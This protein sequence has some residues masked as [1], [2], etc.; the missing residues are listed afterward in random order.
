MLFPLEIFPVGAL[1]GSVTTAV[2]I[3]V[4]V[5]VFYNIRFGTTLSGLVV[6]GYLVPLFLIKP[7]SGWVIILEAIM[8][9]FLAKLI[10]ERALVKAKLGEMF[11]RDRFFILILCS[12]L[13]RVVSDAFVLPFTENWLLE[14][15]VAQ[16]LRSDLH[17]FGLIIIALCANQFWNSGIKAGSATLFLYLITTYLVISEL[18]IPYTNFNISTLSFMYEDIA[19]S[20]LASPK[21]YIILVTAAFIASRMNLKYGWDY[22]GILIPSLLA[23]QW[24][25]PSKIVVTFIE[26][27][28]ILL[29]SQLLLRSPF[30]KNLNIEGGKQ[31]LFFFNIGFLYKILLGFF[32]AG[33]FPYFNITDLYGFGYLLST[34]IALKMY[35]K[36]LAVKMTRTIIQTSFSA[37]LIAS[38][39]G[40]TLTLVSFNPFTEYKA[41]I[42]SVRLETSEINVDEAINKLITTSFNDS[43]PS[44][45]ARSQLANYATESKQFFTQIR[46][47]K[48]LN[49]TNVSNELLGLANLLGF[50]LTLF[51]DQFLLIT[52]QVLERGSGFY[53]INLKSD[54]ELLLSMPRTVE[55][56]LVAQ[57]SFK[58]FKKLNAG[59]LAYSSTRARRSDDGSDDLLLN[60]RSIFQQFHQTLG[61]ENTLQIRRLRDEV[62]KYMG[63]ESNQTL[64]WVKR[65]LPIDFSM[66]DIKQVIGDFDVNWRDLPFQNRQRD[67]MI[68]GFAEIYLDRAGLIKILAQ[69]GGNTLDLTLEK[70]QRISGYLQDFLSESKQLIAKRSSQNYVN[71][72]QS[73]LLYF[74]NLILNPLLELSEKYATPT[75][76]S[77]AQSLIPSIVSAAKQFGYEIFIYRHKSTEDEYIILKET[78]SE[79]GNGEQRYWGTYVIKLGKSSNYFIEIPAPK[80]EVGTFE[81]GIK[82]FEQLDAKALLISG[83]HLKANF[84]GSSLVTSI[85]NRYSLFNLI[86]QTLLRHFKAIKPHAV[87]I[88]GAALNDE[89]KNTI[90]LN[91]Y[92]INR[93]Y[94]K[95]E[96][97][98][99]RLYDYLNDFVTNTEDSNEYLKLGQAKR[100]A[101]SRFLEFINEALYSEIRLPFEIRK[102]FQNIDENSA[103][104]RKLESLNI[105]VN[106]GELAYFINSIASRYINTA[107]AEVISQEFANF[108]STGNI[109]FI[110]ELMKNY[111]SLKLNAVLDKNSLQLFTILKYDE[112]TVLICKLKS[113]TDSVYRLTDF[114][115]L[116]LFIN[117]RDRCLVKE[118]DK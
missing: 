51:K 43:Q 42:G 102:S 81:F 8:T 75:W 5:V 36:G 37:T 111:P 40:F 4:L 14:K 86:H 68:K 79:K 114:K 104:I 39:L 54:S 2:W 60:S 83:A 74:D 112:N 101:Q 30:F 61:N 15:G 50:K 85:E 63:N 91:Y 25:N 98:F 29:L 66:Q 99:I 92:S 19:S 34:L 22:N 12:V 3:G 48:R 20:V 26:A 53:L 33:S 70:E 100:N 45:I 9:Y 24:Y 118:E 65:G 96:P 71:P 38:L 72:T 28:V 89:N 107:Q 106:E 58:L 90:E 84:D 108:E 6:P 41:D 16:H 18:L 95:S 27:F 97:S 49:S 21:A 62:S 17:S 77:E 93:P 10:A 57:V 52:D 117:S 82:L 80:F 94:I 46:E 55:E 7:M 115:E 56:P 64:L 78:L 13:V 73:Q 59:F 31:I 32:V 44:I 23:L 116:A 35:Q 105:E 69:E 67:I 103:V 113:S 1:A 88:R 110:Y 11:G 87:Q 76:L 47:L 109:T